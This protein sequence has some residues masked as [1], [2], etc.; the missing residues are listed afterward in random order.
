L[1]GYTTGNWRIYQQG[2][3]EGYAKFG[4][5]VTVWEKKGDGRFRASVDIAVSHPKLTFAE[6]NK[7]VRKNQ[8][9]DVNKRGWSPA[10]ASM[11]FLRAGMSSERLGG[12]YKRFAADDVRLLRDGVAPIVGKKRVVE[13][14]NDYVSIMFPQK[15]ALFQ[16]ADMAYTWNPCSFDNSNEGQVQGNCLHIWK[17]RKKKWW[18][19]LGVFAP[20]PNETKPELKTKRKD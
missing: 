8:T 7:P 14:M 16:S 1:L 18:I 10:D 2:K 15:V 11:N 6:T 3:S 19:V 13:A 4:Q 17:L 9:R 12:A 5:Y 20:L